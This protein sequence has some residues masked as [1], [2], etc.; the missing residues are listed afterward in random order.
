MYIKRW[1]G[2][3]MKFMKKGLT[4]FIVAA[5]IVSLLAACGGKGTQDSSAE[6]QAQASDSKASTESTAKKEHI[7]LTYL[8]ANENFPDNFKEFLVDYEAKFG[9]K[10]DVQLFPATEYDKMIRTKMMSGQNFDLY[11]TDGIDAAENQWPKD[12]PVDLSDREWVSRLTPAA[13]KII[14]WSDGRITGIPILNNTGLGMMYNKDIFEKVGITELPKSW[15]EFLDDCEKIKQA[16]I[17]PVNIQVANGSE[18]GATH[19]MHQLFSNVYITRGDGVKDLLEQLN[20]HKVK[21]SEVPEFVQ[22]L[23]QIVELRDKGYINEDFISTTYEM[24]QDKFG[25]GEVA[26][27]PCGDFILQPML[28]KYPDLNIGF[29]P[30]PFEVTQGVIASCAGNGL[31]VSSKAKYK[32]EALELVDYFASKEVQEKYMEKSPGMGV[33]SDVKSNDNAIS[34][35]MTKYANM[36]FVAPEVALHFLAWPEMDAR[37]IIQELLLGTKTPEQ[38]LEEIDKKAEIVAKGKNLQGW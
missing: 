28:A 29:F 25:K 38:M 7:T 17:T 3:L 9:N 14:S 18:F 37:K 34:A 23:K 2:Y 10:V 20:T 16:G 27:H 32:E 1:E 8:C 22:S 31:S 5:F 4:I 36:G 15:N 35:D 12:W 26:M 13:K 33:F 30:T 19:L 24:S 6:K 21:Y 11:R